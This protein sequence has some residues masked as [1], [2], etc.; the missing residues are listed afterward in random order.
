MEQGTP[1]TGNRIRSWRVNTQ[2]ARAKHAC[3]TRCKQT[4]DAGALRLQAVRANE[5]TTGNRNT[6]RYFHTHCVDA[7]LPDARRIADFD[8]LSDLDKQAFH[9]AV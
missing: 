5:I 6:G 8:L 3:C 4:F 2:T 7:I 1:P 9:K